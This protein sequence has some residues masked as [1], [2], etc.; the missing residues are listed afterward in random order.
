MC[1]FL[2]QA[3]RVLLTYFVY[4]P[5]RMLAFRDFRRLLCVCLSLVVRLWRGAHVLRVRSAP[6]PRLSRLL[7]FALWQVTSL[8]AKKA[9][10]RRTTK[11]NFG[12]AF[13]FV[14]LRVCCS[15]TSCTLRYA[16]SPFAIFNA[17]S[18]PDYFFVS[19]TL[20]FSSS[21]FLAPAVCSLASHL[22]ASKKAVFKTYNQAQLRLCFFFVRLWARC[23]RTSCTLRA[24]SSSSLTC[25][26]CFVFGQRLT[27]DTVP[28]FAIF[29]ACSAPDYLFVSN[30]LRASFSSFSAFAVCSLA[31]HLFASK[32]A[33]FKTYNKSTAICRAF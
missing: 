6:R 18:A 27:R 3:A 10:S 9:V 17:C 21:S 20:R 19:N 4:A 2:C 32:K 15:R 31:R 25:A 7:P 12:C 24:L 8:Q 26:P 22:F 28:P 29:N 30:T 13:F 1:F 5:L 23:S 33:V 11:H 16:C 14:R